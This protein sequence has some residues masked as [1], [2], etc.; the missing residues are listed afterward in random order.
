M[1]YLLSFIFLAIIALEAPGLIKKKM[2]RELAAFGVL[3]LIGMAYSYG[4]ALDLP[5]PSP[6]AGIEAVFKPV[7]R[8]IEK[9]L[10]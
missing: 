5:V 6:T 8:F 9:I 3:L 10:P 1:V 4:Q 2:W 7:S